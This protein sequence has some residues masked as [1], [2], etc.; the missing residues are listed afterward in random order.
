MLNSGRAHGSR[1]LITTIVGAV[2]FVL[3]GRFVFR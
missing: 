3:L 2:N 1:Y